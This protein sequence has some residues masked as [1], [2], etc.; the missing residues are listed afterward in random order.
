MKISEYAKHLLL[1]PNLED[2]LLSPSRQWEEETE[3][4]ALRIETPG[5]ST[6]LQF[7]DKK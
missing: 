5:R 6:R 4:T 1:A 2:K 3:F 7:S